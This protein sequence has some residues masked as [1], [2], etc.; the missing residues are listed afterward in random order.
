[1]KLRYDTTLNI[2]MLAEAGM[3]LCIGFA[4]AA[5]GWWLL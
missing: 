3:C 5:F 4:F 1:M 2:K